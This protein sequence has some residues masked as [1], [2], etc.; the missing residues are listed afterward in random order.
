MFY[1]IGQNNTGGSFDE[2]DKLCHRLIIEAD[3]ENEVYDIAENL[4]CYWD[5]VENGIDCPCCGDRWYKGTDKIDV[6]EKIVVQDLDSLESWFERFSQFEIV[7]EP[8]FV[9]YTFVPGKGYYSGTIK[10]KNIEEYAKATK[11]DQQWTNP[12]T[13]IFYKNGDIKEIA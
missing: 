1:E 6:K 2:N 3:N 12:D 4:G 7:E 10:T 9:P 11:S 5:G 13:R 8:V